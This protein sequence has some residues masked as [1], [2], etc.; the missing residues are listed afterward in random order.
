MIGPVIAQML[1]DNRDNFL[2]P[3]EVV[4]NVQEDNLLDHALLVLTKVRYSKIPVLDKNSKFKGLLSMPMITETMFGLENFSFEQLHLQRVGDVMEKDVPTV[5]NPYDVEKVMH[6]LVDNAFIP[7]VDSDRN[8]TGIV[9]RREY[10]KSL[11]HIAHDLEQ[12]YTIS[13]KI[14]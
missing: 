10:M 2:I 14:D 9:T 3:A 4:A 8:F 5:E 6:L 12:D 7:V 11:N 13:H 1:E